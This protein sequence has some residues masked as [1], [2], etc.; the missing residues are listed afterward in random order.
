MLLSLYLLILFN[1]KFKSKALYYFIITF[2]KLLSM[3]YYKM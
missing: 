3:M 2:L 1:I